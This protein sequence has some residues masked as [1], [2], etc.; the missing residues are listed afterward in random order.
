MR[1][2]L[3]SQEQATALMHNIW[4]KV[5]AALAAGKKLTLE[6]K[7]ASK[8]REQEEK[9]HAIIGDIAKQAQH[10]GAKWDAEDWKRLLVDKFLRETG[11]K[12]SP[13]IPNLDGTGIVHQAPAYGEDDQRVCNDAGIPTYVS[14]NERGE[15]NSIVTDFEGQ[16]AFDAN[17]PISQLL[18]ANGRVLRQ[19]SYEHPYPHCYRCKNPLIYKAVSSWFVETTKLRDRMVELNQDIDWT[20]DHTKDGSFGKWL[21]NVRDWAISRLALLMLTPKAS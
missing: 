16:H 11:F 15:F 10:M 4:P 12:N 14:I 21:E 9:Y 7:D 6:I 1:Y 5:K 18:K 13:I 2:D 3:D 8:S 19:A 20:P 17:K